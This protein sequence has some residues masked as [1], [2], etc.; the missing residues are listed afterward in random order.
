MAVLTLTLIATAAPDTRAAEDRL[1]W[2]ESPPSVEEATGGKLQVGDVIDKSN[3]DAVKH[4]LPDMY[5]ELITAR[6]W[7]LT[8]N[9]YTPGRQLL[10]PSFIEATTQHKG[11]AA[12]DASGTIT[13]RDGGPWPGGLPAP[14]PQS[15]IEVMANTLYHYSDSW[16]GDYVKE[17]WVNAEDAIYK[18]VRLDLWIMLMTGRTCLTPSSVPG[19]ESELKRQ[20]ILIKD[21][22]DVRGIASLNV[23]YRDQSKL[24]DSWAYVPALRRVQRLS[25]AQR[26]DSTDG[27]DLRLG[28]INTFSDPLGMWEF[29]LLRRTPVFAMLTKDQYDFAEEYEQE[30]T[31]VMHDIGRKVRVE[32][33]PTYVVEALPK[34]PHI[35]SKKVLY[36]DAVTYI[37]WNGDFYDKQGNLW[38]AYTLVYGGIE[39]PCGNTYANLIAFAYNIQRRTATVFPAPKALGVIWRNRS[40]KEGVSVADFTLKKIST[41]AR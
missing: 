14:Q 7:R 30:P 25:A 18:T 27:S 32:L 10:I 38:A 41:Q 35:Y 19:S 28:D 31:K 6:E 40:E 4:L 13:T 24:P 9:P 39:S 33:R 36:V 15:A 26:Y 20:I 16:G 2:E 11:L 12:V 8:I 37:P 17:W 22:Y 5:Y 23:D 21:P 3:V 1:W 34:E 29:K